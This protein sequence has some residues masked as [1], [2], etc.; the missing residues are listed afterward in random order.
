MSRIDLPP[1]LPVDWLLI[2]EQFRITCDRCGAME[3]AP[4]TPC[5]VDALAFYGAYV[6]ELHRRCLVAVADP[7][8]DDTQA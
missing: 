3:A 7:V 4:R 8:D 5:S 1:Y 6:A 2:D